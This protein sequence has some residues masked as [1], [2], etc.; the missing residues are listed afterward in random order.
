MLATRSNNVHCIRHTHTHT[1]THT[2]VCFMTTVGYVACVGAGCCI[3][4]PPFAGSDPM[5][6]YN[7]ILKGIDVIEFPKK[8]GRSAHTLIKRLCRENPAERLGYGKNGI[9]DI[10]KHKYEPQYSALQPAHYSVEQRA[11]PVF[12]RAT[13][14]LGI[15][16]HSS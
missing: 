14:T 10:K 8:I 16:P 1:H 13:I 11:P 7:I 4:S 2:R 12:D 5:K 3:Y 6:T 15:G 9:V